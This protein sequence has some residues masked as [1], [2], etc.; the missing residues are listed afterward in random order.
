[1]STGS[2]KEV[3]RQKYGQAALRVTSG[4]SNS[5]CGPDCSGLEGSCDPITSNLYDAAQEGEVPDTAI[6][7]S[8]GCGNLPHSPN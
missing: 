3:V 1:M 7:P 5:C 6:K 2:V 4:D 8:L